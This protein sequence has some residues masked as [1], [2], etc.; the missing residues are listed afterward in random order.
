MR[1]NMAQR[2]SRDLPILEPDCV[3]QHLL[4]RLFASEFQGGR[5]RTA[6]TGIGT[7]T[8]EGLDLEPSEAFQQPF[9]NFR[10]NCHGRL[11]V[12]GEDQVAHLGEATGQDLRVAEDMSTKGKAQKN[13]FRPHRD[14]FV[15]PVGEGLAPVP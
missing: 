13:F 3:A 14:F 15:R 6:R 9:L 7:R 8:F 10:R 5:I 12:C 2:M 11:R 4:Q 1:S